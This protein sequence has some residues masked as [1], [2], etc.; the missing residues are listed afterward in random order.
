[1]DASKVVKDHVRIKCEGEEVVVRLEY[2]GLPPV[3]SL[4][5]VFGHIETNCKK[6]PAPLDA[7]EVGESY[8]SS[9]SADCSRATKRRNANKTRRRSY[10][11][12]SQSSMNQVDQKMKSSSECD[13]DPTEW[14]KIRKRKNVSKGKRHE[15]I[16]RH[17]KTDAVNGD[18]QHKFSSFHPASSERP[19]DQLCS[20]VHDQTGATIRPADLTGC[21]V[22]P[23]SP[24]SRASLLL[25]AIDGAGEQG[26]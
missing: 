17:E 26:N 22:P 11:S 1:I 12:V 7:V 16:K 14:I 15:K 10:V 3:C 6:M 18:K 23:P 21:S 13:S 4:C 5:V 9:D 8:G 25:K 2:Q 24:A 19:S 20:S